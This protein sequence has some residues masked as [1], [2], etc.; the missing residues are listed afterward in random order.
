MSVIHTSLFTVQ[1]RFPDHKDALRQKYRI[2]KKFISICNDYQK[3]E[4]ALQYWTASE[5]KN[6]PE[7]QK[8]YSE[9]L[10]ELELEIMNSLEDSA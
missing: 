9:L 8:E 7:R 5:D 1:K 4:E 3:C 2:D 6:A 10:Q